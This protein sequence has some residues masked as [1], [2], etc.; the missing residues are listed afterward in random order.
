M[1]ES[2]TVSK[3]VVGTSEGD[4]DGIRDDIL[5]GK[6][7]VG[8][9]VG[10]IVAA[11]DGSGVGEGKGI[12]ESMLAGLGVVGNAEGD[13]VRVFD[14]VIFSSSAVGKSIGGGLK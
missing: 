7:V 12:V 13:V 4:G 6:N 10:D 14:C 11:T 9:F 1:T 5:L 2:I 3:T 8:W